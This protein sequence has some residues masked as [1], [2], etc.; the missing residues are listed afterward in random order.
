MGLQRLLVANRGEIAIRIARAASE[1]GITTVA[2]YAEDDVNA[3]HVRRAD[4]A[5]A[6][7][8]S[9]ARAYLDIEQVVGAAL[10]AGCDSIHPGYG[11]LSENAGLARRCAEAGLTFVGPSP[12]VLDLF[13][14][15]AAARALALRVGVPVLG[16]SEGEVTAEEA[17]RFLRGLGDGGAIAIKAIAGGG[18]RGIRIVRQV[19]EVSDAYARCQ[20]EAAGAFGNGA[21]YVEQALTGARHIEIQVAG[22][23]DGTV[24]HFGERECT[25]QRRH[26]KLLEIAPSPSI[27]GD[28]RDRIA[29]A[30]VAMAREAGYRSLG[31]FEF[32]VGAGAGGVEPFFFIEANPRLQVEHTVTEEVT[33]VDLVHLQLRVAG[34]DTL[35]SLGYSQDSIPTAR[36]FAIQAR[37]NMETMGADGTTRPGGGQI[38]V[39]EAPSGPGVRTDG[40]GYSGYRTSPAYDSLLAKVIA[41]SPSS[42]FEDAVIRL[43]RA[44]ADFR[45]EGVP[46]NLS[47]LRALVQQEAVRAG[48]VTTSF[49]DEHSTALFNAASEIGARAAEADGGGTALAG[50]RVD[51]NDPLA[52]LGHGKAVAGDRTKAAAGPAVGPDGS[53]PVVALL[54]GTIVSVDVAE[55][56]AVRPG[57]QIAVM[58]AMKME[59]EVRAT[60]G[61]VITRVV[62]GPGDTVYEGATLF[63]LAPSEVVVE[64]GDEVEEVD[65]SRIRPDLKE[66]L[67]RIALTRDEARPKAVAR[68]RATGQRTAR[69]NIADLCGDSFVEYGS[70]VLANQRSRRSLEEL[71]EKSPADGMITGIGSVNGDLFDGQASQCAILSYDYTVFAGTQ[72]NRN[73]QKTDRM[74]EIAKRGG[75]PVIIFTEGGGGRPGEDGDTGGTHTFVSFPELSGLVPLVGINSGRCFAGNAALLGMC[76]VIIATRDSNIGM[77]G[78]AMVEGGGL[79]VFTPEEI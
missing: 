47:F 46:T 12:E 13:G 20:S 37:V 3:L 54:Q 68:R 11:F 4:E 69:E 79:G 75:M 17:E 77:G 1:L 70:L 51:P 57:Q 27:S 30:A 29:A 52:V 64:G 60:E 14:D 8:G 62:V 6:L 48:S 42:R 67:D 55:G 9:G 50:A 10:A 73:H 39:Y 25:L 35:A 63:F 40:Y 66:V 33:G 22:D 31:T 78:P 56:D 28:T 58:E 2:V 38:A 49:I 16:G 43:E 72:G 21:V 32:L 45:I 36:G 59:H 24:V 34:G 74:L 23:A 41:H 76:D 5:V 44:L 15:K 19:S 53:I 65:L 71:I 61:G 7:A 26:Q 18:G